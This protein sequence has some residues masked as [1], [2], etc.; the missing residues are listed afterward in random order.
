MN[1]Y[2]VFKG[3]WHTLKEIFIKDLLH[4][5]DTFVRNENYVS[6]IQTTHESN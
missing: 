2:Q 3:N 5:Q 6:E 1:N 4:T